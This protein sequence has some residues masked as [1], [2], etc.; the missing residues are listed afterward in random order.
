MMIKLSNFSNIS[1]NDFRDFEKFT[2]ILNRSFILKFER[3]D[4]N[5]IFFAIFF[6]FFA[7]LC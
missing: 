7:D 4:D 6:V 5:T 2:E 1:I 3:V